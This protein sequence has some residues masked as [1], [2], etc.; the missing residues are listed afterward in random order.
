MWVPVRNAWRTLVSMRTALVLLFLLALA[1][2]PGALLP[3]R[4]LNAT[5]VDAYIA[6]HPTF[7][8]LMNRVGLFEVFASPWFAAVYGLLFI[9]LIGCLLPRS[10]EHLRHLRAKPPVAPRNLTRLPH[11]YT[12]TTPLDPDA[13]ADAVAARLGRWRTTRR[14]GTR[15]GEVVVSAERGH[16]REWG[17]LVFHFSLVGLLI[18]I[19]MGKLFGY[20]GQVIAVADGGP[21]SEICN[22]STAAYDTFRAGLSENGTGLVP[23]CVRVNSFTAEYLPSGQAKTFGAGI[24]YQSGA[25]L[26]TNTWRPYD[27]AVNHPLRLDGDRVYLL[28]HGFAPKFTVTYPDGETRSQTLQFRPVDASTLLSEGTLRFDPPAGLYASADDRRRNQI[29]VTGL[30]APSAQLDGKL[31]TSAGPELSDPEVAVDVLRGDAGLDS[32]MPQ[33]IFTLDPQLESS[34]RLVRQARVNLKPGQSVSLSDGTRVTFNSVEQ[35]VSLQ[36]SHDPGQIY[37]LIFAIT[38]TAGLMGSLVVKRRRIWV[39]LVPPGPGEPNPD[40]V[41]EVGGL[42]RTDQAGWGEEFDRLAPALAQPL[43]NATD[44]GEKTA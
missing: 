42:A 7:G 5:K 17:N 2:V 37:V 39:R 36:T 29:A 35:W 12:G 4:S 44:A 15:P 14:A 24:D 23:F 16:L 33:S 32:G 11:S 30:F 19:G 20:E 41:V 25:D 10:A 22:T 40:T 26:R 18:G 27:L 8:P 21:G 38:M 13:A 1:S 28:G 34:G 9:S 6:N 43:D 31:L 3:Q